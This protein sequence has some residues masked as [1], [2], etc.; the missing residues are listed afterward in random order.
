MAEDVSVVV[1]TT[2]RDR[3]RLERAIA[4][5]A[6]QTVAPA[7]IVVVVDRP[8]LARLPDLE[9]QVP[10]RVIRNSRKPGPSG[11]RNTGIVAARAHLVALLDDDDYWQAEKLEH[12]FALRAALPLDA[13]ESAVIATRGQLR[14]GNLLTGAPRKLPSSSERLVSYLYEPSTIRR[15]DRMIHTSSLMVPKHFATQHPLDEDMRHWEDIEWLLRMSDAG[16]VFV[17]CP[18]LLMVYDRTPSGSPSLSRQRLADGDAAWAHR[19]LLP[20]STRAYHNFRLT[21][22]AR[23]MMDED[24]RSDAL[25]IGWDSIRSRTWSPVS[26]VEFAAFVALSATQRDRLRALRRRG[27]RTLVLLP[28]YSGHTRT[29]AGLRP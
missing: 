20:R 27:A 16:A 3:G 5:A 26:A 11:A 1:P 22:V 21:H 17:C 18:Q 24:R 2:L 25:R 10:V 13:R 8:E 14:D 28:G 12:Q 7:E 4:S 9:A 23:R 29:S 6:A 19:V 15:P